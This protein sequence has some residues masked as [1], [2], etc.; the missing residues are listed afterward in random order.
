MQVALAAAFFALAAGCSRDPNPANLPYVTPPVKAATPAGLLP[1]PVGALTNVRPS[2]ALLSSS[3]FASRFFTSPG[4]TNIFSVL[5]VIDARLAEINGMTADEYYACVSQVPIAYEIAPFGET[6]TFYAQCWMGGGSTNAADPAFVQFGTKD[7]VT[8]LYD[9]HWQGRVAA[10][11]TPIPGAAGKY[12]VRAWLGTGYMNGVDCGPTWDG[13]SYSVLELKADESTNA[14]EMA[15]AG[16][17]IG[18]CG[19]QLR[20]DGTDVFVVGSAE[21]CGAVDTLCVAA[22]DATT[23]SAGC[24]AAG[25]AS[26]E[27]PA[28]GRTASTSSTGGII[29]ASE[30]PGGASNTIV[31]DGTSSDSL[32]FGPTSPTRGVGR[33]EN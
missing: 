11:V 25:L 12:N 17:A 32:H 18:Y 13:C 7:G 29:P 28:L 23:P 21:G 14:F 1:P 15:A 4:P 31:L 24:A 22:G 10:I 2:G 9:A 20:S 26:F 30:Y 16:I 19:A 3:D 6:K 8:Y 27:L 33:L 5:G